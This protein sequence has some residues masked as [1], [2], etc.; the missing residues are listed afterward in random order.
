MTQPERT[1]DFVV[2]GGGTAGCVLAA[3]LSEEPQ[4]RVC[5][6]EAGGSG[7]SLYVNVPGAI[8]LAQRS[9]A[10]NWRF[11]TVP[12]PQL[13]GRRIP[14]PRGRGLGGSGTHQRHGVFPRAS[15]GLRRVVGSGRHGLELSRSAAVLLQERRQRGL[16]RLRRFTAAAAR[17]ASAT[18]GGRTR[19]ISRSSRRSR[20]WDS[21]RARTSTAE[22]PKAWRLRQVSI[23][24][25][26]RETTA[27]ALLRPALK[28]ANLTVLTDTQATRV[29][30]E[31]R[32]AVARGSAHGARRM[33]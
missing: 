2:V 9:A 11:Q 10:L 21:R 17:C 7:E 20:G 12:Q 24:G 16:S 1:F 19:S 32:R 28:R 13:N 8:V 15:A 4:R 14:I 23:R 22:T 26:T 3:R 30:L 6:I 33:S 27:S 18:C 5:L 31:G 29:V 25:G